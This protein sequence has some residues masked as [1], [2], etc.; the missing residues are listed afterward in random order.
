MGQDHGPKGT[1]AGVGTAW[2]RVVG[3]GLELGLSC[4]CE[5]F[6]LN[7]ILGY[8]KILYQPGLGLVMR[9]LDRGHV[10]RV[11]GYDGDSGQALVFMKRVGEGYPGNVGSPFGGTNCQ[12]VLR[13]LIARS[14]YLNGQIPC[15]ETMEVI[16]ALRLALLRFEER[17]ARRH[18]R[19]LDLSE[20]YQ[21][22]EYPSCPVCGHIQCGGH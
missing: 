16:G 20:G 19:V 14:L 7:P 5:K 2:Q 10:Y 6:W 15:A 22:E 17:A 11:A 4:F 12:E 1:R 8:V 18:G 3:D 21:I 9:E 13:A